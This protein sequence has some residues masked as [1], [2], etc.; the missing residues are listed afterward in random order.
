MP[1]DASQNSTLRRGFVIGAVG[2]RYLPG[3]RLA[4]FKSISQVLDDLIEQKAGS[5]VEV[6]MLVS[7]A[8]GADRLFIEAA[9]SRRIP[10][11]CVL[12]CS[13]RCFE[14]DFDEPQSIAEYH[15]LLSGARSIVQPEIDPVERVGG[16]LWA[17]HYI[18]DRADV[19]VAVWDGKPA[20]GPAGTGDSV[21]DAEERCVPVIWIPT[22]APHEPI[23]LEMAA[24]IL[25]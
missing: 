14:S 12:P 3:E 10:Y 1:I 9:I 11:S 18:L 4:L 5:S 13:P 2:H 17:N 19:L 7:V 16:Y 24:F 8:E 21:E 22:E 20:N 23:A 6:D 15:Q 25:D